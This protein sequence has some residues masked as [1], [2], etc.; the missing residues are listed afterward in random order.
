MQITE[1]LNHFKLIQIWLSSDIGGGNRYGSDEK[2]NAFQF[3]FTG[4]ET[5]RNYF[6]CL[7]IFPFLDWLVLKYK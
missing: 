6:F 2:R 4:G 3:L 7:L 1:S 5:I